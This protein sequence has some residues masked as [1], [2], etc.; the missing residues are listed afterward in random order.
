[1][2]IRYCMIS[3]KTFFSIVILVSG[4]ILSFKNNWFQLSHLGKSIRLCLGFKKKK[5]RTTDGITPFQAMATA[6]GGSIGT[7]NI[8]G[9]AGAIIMGG[10]GAIFW[11]W[12]AAFIGMGVKYSEIVLALEYRKRTPDG[13]I[14]GAMFYIEQGFN[15]HGY[16]L[17]KL[18]KPMAVAFAIFGCLAAL[19][20][21]TLV[22]SNTI[23]LSIIDLINE[24]SVQINTKVISL[25]CGLIIAFLVGIVVLGGA[26]RISRVSGYVVP[27]M[28]AGY[29]IVGTIA[30]YKFRINLPSAF[31]SII[32]NAFG[33]KQIGG[34]VVGYGLLRIMRTGI[35]KGIYSNEAG[36]GS[37]PMAHACATT[38]DSV[39]Q[40]LYGIFEVFVDTIV[41]CSITALVLLSSGINIPYGQANVS[42]TEIVLEAF[43]LAFPRKIMSIFLAVS[44]F[45]FAYT[46]II[47]WSVY[48]IQCVKYLFN[49]KAERVFSLFY[50]FFCIIGSVC[51]VEIVWMLG[52]TLNYL[53]A[54]P[55][56]AAV[57]LLSDKV[58]T[59]TK[60]HLIFELK[61]S[62][63]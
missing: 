54:V 44:I 48:G 33:M 21:T 34:G 31:L 63:K 15:R 55:N 50:T 40:G 39:Q 7:A 5:E 18:G 62:R 22:Q 13:Y 61:M 49:N 20:G 30:L 57:L 59:Q 6:L 37:A 8:A 32:T 46:S 24:F 47:G 41:V 19:I 38:S 45:L 9:V 26:S 14:G 58:G 35:S 60:K 1:M 11:M 56:L 3:F 43:S 27:F 4:I 42:G 12:V 51:G 25:V 53:M 52:E 29:L 17:K 2:H 23:T 28:A 16:L 10:P 36:I